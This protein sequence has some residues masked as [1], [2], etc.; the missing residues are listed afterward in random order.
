M[1]E[2]L[3]LKKHVWSLH[4]IHATLWLNLKKYVWSLHII[5]MIIFLMYD[6]VHGMKRKG[7]VEY[8]VV[9]D[10]GKYQAH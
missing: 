2:H 9:F 10:Y 5:Q 6:Y 7:T 8:V 4:V 1:I 3:V